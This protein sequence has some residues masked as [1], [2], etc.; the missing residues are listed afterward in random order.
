VGASQHLKIT[1]PASHN[2][3]SN[4]N[5]SI[6]AIVRQC[7]SN[8]QVMISK[9]TV[10]AAQLQIFRTA[11]T[12]RYSYQTRQLLQAYYELPIIRFTSARA[13]DVLQGPSDGKEPILIRSC[14]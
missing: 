6:A 13:V 5:I 1:L 4:G 7:N 10:S 8:N 9:K 14:T 2:I 11:T 12:T 3:Y